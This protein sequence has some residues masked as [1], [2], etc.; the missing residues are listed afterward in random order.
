MASAV[1]K[2]IRNIKETAEIKGRD[3]AELLDTTEETVSRWNTGKV[4][5]RRDHLK[6]LLELEYLLEELAE[7]YEPDEA[8]LWLYKPHPLLEG[9]SPASRIK[10][11]RTESVLALLEQLRS[12][13]YA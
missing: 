9:S 11:D 5:P 2:R 4:E 12:G 13:A 8:K 10:E 6:R 3:V 1:A 7:F